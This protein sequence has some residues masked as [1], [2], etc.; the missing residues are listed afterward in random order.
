[1]GYH[2]A[3]KHNGFSSRSQTSP[4][5]SSFAN[6]RTQFKHQASPQRNAFNYS[7]TPHHNHLPFRQKLKKLPPAIPPFTPWTPES[8]PESAK[9]P[10]EED[11]CPACSKKQK[12]AG[13]E[14]LCFQFSR[15][16]GTLT[17]SFSENFKGISKPL[18][19]TKRPLS[20]E[21]A[22]FYSRRAKHVKLDDSTEDV[23]NRAIKFANWTRSI[24][25]RRTNVSLPLTLVV[26]EIS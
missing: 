19:G 4:L 17:D 26:S 16:A 3:K 23:T 15:S 13:K 7:K 8:D 1:M 5:S 24:R 11:E 22:P 14:G 2:S 12:V 20:E 18:V 6:P 9:C 10:H 21:D 25:E